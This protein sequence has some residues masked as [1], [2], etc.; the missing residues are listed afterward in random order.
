[1]A[2]ALDNT[3]LHALN[4][5]ARKAANATE[6]V[7]AATNYL[8]NYIASNPTPKIQFRA[9]D[10]ILHIDSDAAFQ[11]CDMARSRAGGYHYLGSKDG[12]QFNAP[13]EVLAKV[14]KPVMGSAAEAEVAALYLNAQ[15]AIPLRYCLEELGHPQPATIIRTDNQT[16]KG[17]VRGTIKQK[18]SRTF[19]RQYWWLKDREVQLQFNIVWEPGIYNLADY[20]TKHHTG[21]HHLQVRPIYL[22]CPSSPTSL[23][24][25]AKIFEDKEAGLEITRMQKCNGV[26]DDSR[27]TQIRD[28]NDFNLSDWNS[29]INHRDPKIP[30]QRT[31]ADSA[32]KKDAL[33][34]PLLHS[35]VQ[36]YSLHIM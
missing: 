13:I 34:S 6:K 21:K 11:V 22:H 32:R 25:C 29:R 12:R 14:I 4:E 20:F 16:A 2:R 36:N 8:L 9:S 28:R 1:M 15:E 27:L 3:L 19:D 24:G 18:R 35:V 10:M 30:F 17:F 23:Q 5:L 7:L 33:N 31:L 26:T